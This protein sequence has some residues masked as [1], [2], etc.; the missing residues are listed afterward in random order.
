MRILITGSSGML[1][2]ALCEALGK[3][4]ETAGLDLNEPR[5]GL[6]LPDKF[7]KA[8]ILE[9]DSL[10]KA[11]E[12]FEPGLI[13]HSAAWTDVDGCET[14]PDKAYLVNSRGTFNVAAASGREVPLILISTDFVFDGKKGAP[15]GEEDEVNPL[16]VYGKSKLNAENS[17]KDLK[18][19][20][21]IVRTSWL[22]GRGGKNFVDTVMQK[23][24]LSGV[25]KV[26]D[27]QVGSPTYCPDLARA[28]ALIARKGFSGGECLL[29]ISNSGRCSWYEYALKIIEKCG[30]S[31]S[32][33]IERVSSRELGRPAA[34]PAFSVMDTSRF[35]AVSGKKLRPWEEALDEYINSKG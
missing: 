15:Y 20:F 32:V 3:D 16:S 13:V 23:G 8:D 10:K 14:D 5:G 22:F 9:T 4:H 12:D 31:E 24:P 30:L 21:C 7:Y 1:G 34:R 35:S 18:T 17:V 2:V 6:P 19:H 26:V 28:V 33:R 25:L 29:H 27:D 11:V